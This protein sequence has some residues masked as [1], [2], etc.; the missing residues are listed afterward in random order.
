MT[1]CILA[2]ILFP[3]TV[4]G[5]MTLRDSLQ[6][7]LPHASQLIERT[8]LLLNIL[9]LS[10]NE[11]QELPVARRLYHH[12]LRTNDTFALGA[13]LGTMVIDLVGDRSCQDSL[14]QLLENAEVIFKGSA[15]EG[16]SYYYR[17][18]YLLRDI[19]TNNQAQC[20]QKC[21][22]LLHTIHTK[23]PQ[24]DYERASQFFI[25]ACINYTLAAETETPCGPQVVADL[26][27]AWQ[28][29]QTFPYNSRKNFC[30]N[31][32]TMLSHLYNINKETDKLIQISNIY[33]AILD[34]FFALPTVTA[35][36]PYIY[37]DNYYL[38][39]YQQLMLNEETIGK[40]KAERYFRLFQKFMRHGRGDVRQRDKF[41]LYTYSYNYYEHKKAYP[42][43]LLYVDSLITQIEQRNG[44]N[45]KHAVYYQSRAETLRKM[46]RYSDACEAYARAQVVADSLTHSA[47]LETT[48]RMQVDSEINQMGIARAQISAHNEQIALYCSIGLL[49]IAAGYCV[50]IYRRVKQTERLQQTLVYQRQQAD[51]NESKK[52]DFIN[53]ICHE[54]RTP[55][56][57]IYGF[58]ELIVDEKD[59]ALRKEYTDVINENCS[60]MT[61]LLKDMLEVTNLTNLM[62]PLLLQD[63]DIT[64][65]CRRAVSLQIYA[66]KKSR[67]RLIEGPSIPMHTNTHYFILLIRSLLNNAVKFAPQGE[68]TLT[69]TKVANS[70]NIQI[71]VTDC[72][73]G[74]PLEEQEHVFERFV[75]LNSFS[76]GNGLG[77]Y[78]CR[79]IAQ[80]LKGEIHIDPSYTNGTRVV[81]TL[82]PDPE[83]TGKNKIF[84]A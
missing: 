70:K 39:C 49:L 46:G 26:E 59:V 28:L 15:E 58:S 75:K 4:I 43:A 54:V 83:K 47:I 24:N 31:I 8:E 69:W 20:I 74:I 73:C 25:T 19:P 60:R 3:S 77:L 82:P 36:R 55:L 52:T 81:F 41:Y 78:L 62:E 66:T 84:V 14:F 79:L 27:S 44:L 51:A 63:D 18:V 12:A 48:S 7:K 30:C 29:A 45:T 61:V 80:A 64:T 22:Q 17:M 16:L 2:C 76:Q 65:L 13:S 71:T 42:E 9:D 21:N 72:G 34:Q 10:E 33:L 5:Q 38:L 68:I 6:A 67:I 1:L 11:E 40:E 53:S 35:R 37:K 32:Y 56:N 57:S 50:Y 23:P